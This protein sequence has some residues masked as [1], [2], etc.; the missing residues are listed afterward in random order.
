MTDQTLTLWKLMSEDSSHSPEFR[1]LLRHLHSEAMK[2]FSQVQ[3]KLLGP[4]S[5]WLDIE[6]SH[7]LLIDEQNVFISAA[8]LAEMAACNYD[9]CIP[10]NFE[11]LCGERLTEAVYTQ[12]HYEIAELKLDTNRGQQV[13]G[14]DRFH[15]ALYQTDTMKKLCQNQSPIDLA[16]NSTLPDGVRIA[17][18]GTYF[19]F[20]GYYG[21]QR[22]DI[23][24]KIPP[25]VRNV[26][27]VGCGRGLTGKAIKERFD[28]LVTGA[29]LNPSVA[30]EARRH[31]DSVI[32]EDIEN[33][34]IPKG[35]DAIV[36]TELFEHLVE[37]E[38]FLLNCHQAL[39]DGGTLIMT[40]PNV[41]HYQV[42]EDLLA[43]RWDY[44]AAGLLCYTHLRF[45]TRKTLEDW[46]L[47]SPFSKFSIESETSKLPER[48]EQLSHV[49]DIDRESLAT[50]SFHVTL[51]K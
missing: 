34:S 50:L 10:S 8:S 6:T 28:C 2:V 20:D 37:P 5:D 18:Y 12:R 30:E 11:K 41:G 24:D 33:Y 25:T 7:V 16:R 4:S 14:S 29:E 13:S 35:F 31:L 15:L 27:E 44:V 48:I 43:G 46:F 40:I 47:R 9:V 51:I 19:L 32:C 36:A 49:V 3:I 38:D 21:N 23:L 45:F 17:N 1:Y 42:V 39:N 26:L 22:L